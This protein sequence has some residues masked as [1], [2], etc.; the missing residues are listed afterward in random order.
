MDFSWTKEQLEYK[1][2]VINFA[3]SNLNHAVMESDR[4]SVFSR[5]A[6]EKCAEFGL[7]GLAVPKE[8][9]GQ[10]DEVQ[11]LTAT[12]AMEALGY[13]CRDNG[14]CLGLNAQMWTVQYPIAQFC[15]AEQKARFLPNLV[16]GKW[17]G[18][19]ALTEPEAGSDIYKMQTRA[20][21]VDG[22]YIL[23]GRK[24]Y[25]TFAPIADIMLVFATINPDLGNFGITGFIVEKGMKGVTNGENKAKMGLRTAPFGDLVFKDCFV[26]EENRV[27][28]EGSGWG[29]TIQTLEY[30]R[31]NILAWQLGSMEYQLEQ[32]IQYVKQRKQFGKPI[33]EFQAVSN[34]LADMRLRLETS[35]LLLYKV[36]WLNETG[37]SA[38]LES[39]MLKLLLSESFVAS[40]LDAI[41]NFGGH[42][43]IS[44]N[45][46][47]RDMRDAVGGLIYAGTSDIQRNIIS[48]L[49][50]DK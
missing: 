49:I 24:Q 16:S 48:D 25:I 31:S 2:R 18:C 13:G 11:F 1:E 6:W 32:T 3:K 34:R 27:S 50:L 23:N 10:F 40:S 38:A 30:D 39:A 37:K 20:E 28:T 45:E 43:Y 47:E 35:R 12:L 41:R 26:P 36:A 19:H 9:G 17:I 14:L 29:I 4:D 15:N 46:I 22:G 33:V 8:Y 42:G 21:K 7:Q 44:E 5:E